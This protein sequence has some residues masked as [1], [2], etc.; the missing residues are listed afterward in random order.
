MTCRL[1]HKGLETNFNVNYLK[2]IREL[3]V[4]TIESAKQ[5]ES[6]KLSF[7]K[8]ITV[9]VKIIDK[10]NIYDVKVIETIMNYVPEYL[11]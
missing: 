1:K 2:K 3:I 4:M 6:E 5:K 7:H 11:A 10:A 9:I 8:M